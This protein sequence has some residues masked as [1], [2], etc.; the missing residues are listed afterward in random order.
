[1]PRCIRFPYTTLFRSVKRG[2]NSVGQVRLVGGS[3]GYDDIFTVDVESG[4]YLTAD[5][6]AAGRNVA[7][8]GYEIAQALFPNG[9]NPMGQT[10]RSEEHTSELQSRENL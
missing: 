8:I 9:E 6:L 5:E 3:E 4:R 10:I 1:A 2:S 7:I